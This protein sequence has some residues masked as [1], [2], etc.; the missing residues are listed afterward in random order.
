M[1]ESEHWGEM[2]NTKAAKKAKAMDLIKNHDM[3]GK[4]NWVEDEDWWKKHAPDMDVSN[5]SEEKASEY[6][7]LKKKEERL[8]KRCERHPDDKCKDGGKV[9]TDLDSIREK[10]AHH[11]DELHKDEQGPADPASAEAVAGETPPDGAGGAADADEDEAGGVDD[12]EDEAGG[13]TEAVAGETSPD[14]AGGAADADEDEAG[15]VEDDEDEAG[16]PT[17]A[18]A[19]G[20]SPGGEETE[21]TSAPDGADGVADAVAA[22]EA[23]EVTKDTEAEQPADDYDEDEPVEGS[24]QNRIVDEYTVLDQVGHDSSSFV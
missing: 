23:G 20:T 1:E 4:H 2:G 16:G 7:K 21:E 18:V 24:I 6:Y 15:D 9:A 14:G 17:E 12:D 10:L 8:K 3:V 19:E 5:M 22:N 11:Y 13:P